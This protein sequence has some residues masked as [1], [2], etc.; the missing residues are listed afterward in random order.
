MSPLRDHLSRRVLQFSV[1][2]NFIMYHFMYGETTNNHKEGDTL[3]I[4]YITSS[5]LD[6][7]H[8]S[9]NASDIDVAVL[10]IARGNLLTCRNIY[11]GVSAERLTSAV[12]L[13]FLVDNVQKIF[14]HCLTG[15]DTVGKFHN[16]SKD[17][18]T[19]LF[20][21]IKDQVIFNVFESLQEEVMPK[22][23]DDLAKFVCW[24]CINKAKRLNLIT[25][26]EVRVHLYKQKNASYEKVPRT[27]SSFYKHILRSFHQLRQLAT[28]GEALIDVQHPLEYGRKEKNGDYIPT[29]TANAFTPSF[30]VELISFNCKYCKKSCSCHSNG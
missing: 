11:F 18:W 24:D 10:L 12:F 26:E 8:V 15:C 27:I 2:G 5:K 7:K 3:L 19:K 23:V 4:H 17:S 25:L 13:S 14:S 21:Q 20:L 22:T 6:G 28:A 29:T 30:L 16:V 9:I 1:A